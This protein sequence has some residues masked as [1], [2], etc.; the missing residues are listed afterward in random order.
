MLLFIGACFGLLLLLPSFPLKLL[1]FCTRLLR[2]EDYNDRQGGGMDGVMAL[3]HFVFCWPLCAPPLPGFPCP[4]SSHLIEVTHPTC[5]L[6]YKSM[7][8]SRWLALFSLDGWCLQ[9]HRF[10]FVWFGCVLLTLLFSYKLH[11]H[12]THPTPFTTLS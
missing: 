2:W 8:F 3:G 5:G 10:G 12:L 6:I 7:A 11:T 9:A 1:P 4:S